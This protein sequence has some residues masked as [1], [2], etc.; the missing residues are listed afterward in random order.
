MIL[1][2]APPVGQISNLPAD[3]RSAPPPNRFRGHSDAQVGLRPTSQIRDLRHSGVGQISNLSA[4][5]R[6]APKKQCVFIMESTMQG[7]N[8]FIAVSDASVATCMM[9]V[10]DKGLSFPLFMGCTETPLALLNGELF[11]LSAETD[12]GQEIWERIEAAAFGSQRLLEEKASALLSQGEAEEARRLLHTWA[13]RCTDA[14][15]AVL[16]R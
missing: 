8:K 16:R 9:M 3:R 2:A 13:K 5:R 12:C 10:N 7:V 6:N 15:L 11:S 4:V 1:W 14:H